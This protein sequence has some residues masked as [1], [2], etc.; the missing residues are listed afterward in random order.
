MGICGMGLKPEE[1]ACGGRDRAGSWTMGRPEMRVKRD[2]CVAGVQALRR[3]VQEIETFTDNPGDD[4]GGDASARPGF[5]NGKEPASAR[6]RSHDGVRIER[7]DRAQIDDFDFVTFRDEVLCR[8]EGFVKHGAIGD[9]GQVASFTGNAGFADGERFGGEGISFE[10]IVEE[11]VFAED[12]GIIKLNGSEK[13]AVGVFNRGGSDDHQA[14]V[15]AVDRFK[16]LAV[17][18]TAAR[19]AAG[20]EADRNGTGYLSAPKEGGGL[21][22]NLVEAHGGE[23][24]ELEFED[25]PEPFDGGSHSQA[26]HGI[27]TDGRINDASREFACEIL[28]GFECAAKSAHVLTINEDSGIVAEGAGLG[29]TNRFEVSNAHNSWSSVRCRDA[30]ADQSTWNG[31]GPGSR[32]EMEIASST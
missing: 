32:W 26:N 30:R 18:W 17:E 29:L 9:D 24:S 21:V 1:F 19:C 12:H 10:M 27:F 5:A 8:S 31:S 23:I 6:D 28:G 11:F 25:G 22:H 4:L 20:R 16:A 15:M 13:H 3:S 14:G 2:G 7:F